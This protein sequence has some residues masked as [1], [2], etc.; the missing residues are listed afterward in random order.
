MV[1]VETQQREPFPVQS[2]RRRRKRSEWGNYLFVLP[3]VLFLAAFMIYPMIFN[4]QMS[5]RDV[6]AETLLSGGAFVGF[7][8]YAAVLADPVTR[9]TLINSIVFTVVCLV[10]QVGIGLGLALFYNLRFPG[11]KF[12]RGLYLIAWTIPIVVSGVTFK[13]LFEGD[14]GF[15]NYLLISAG[16]IKDPVYW[17]ADANTALWA[18]IIV[19]IWLGVPFFLTLMYTALQTIPADLYEAASID[20]ASAIERF[21]HITLPMIRPA[22][23]SSLILG[24]IYTIKVFDLVWVTTQGGPLDASQ[25]VSTLAYKFVFNQFQFGQGS[26]LLN[27][28]FLFLFVVT[29]F[30]LRSVDREAKS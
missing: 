24:L 12:M 10:F 2:V 1:V 23:T 29:L 21:W 19:N 18:I 8:N 27:L 25:L 3:A 28:L 4:I 6:K 22:L 9:G 16:I 17:M 20:G 14:S 5:F 7:Q 30:Y 11:A 13:W 15:I 26:A